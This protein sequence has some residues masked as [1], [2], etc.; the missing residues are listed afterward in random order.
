MVPN[1]GDANR[2]LSLDLDGEFSQRTP[3]AEPVQIP[4]Q[5]TAT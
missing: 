2:P 5:S 1:G 4:L 3:L